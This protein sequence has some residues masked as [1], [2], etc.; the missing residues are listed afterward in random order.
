ME[1]LQKRTGGVQKGPQKPGKSRKKEAGA[2][3]EGVET[4]SQGFAEAAG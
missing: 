4:A 2:R 3:R 1:L